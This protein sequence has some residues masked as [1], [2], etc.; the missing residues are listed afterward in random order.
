MDSADAIISNNTPTASVED[1]NR[2][3]DLGR[4]LMSVLEPEE[5]KAIQGFFSDAR[6]TDQIGNTSDS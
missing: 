5:V 3:L 1:V 6:T 2:L 4:L